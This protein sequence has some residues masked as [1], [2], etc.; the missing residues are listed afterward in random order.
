M[1]CVAALRGNT[2][3]E[4]RVYDSRNTPLVTALSAEPNP[5]IGIYTDA[6]DRTEIEGR[7]IYMNTRAL[8]LVLELGVASAETTTV[9]GQQI[10][11][12]VIPYTDEG[13]EATLDI[14]E[15]Q[16]IGCLFGNPR[17]EWTDLLKR[18]I[19]RITR[20]PSHRGGSAER[21]IRWAARQLTFV[22]D[23][24]FDFPPGSR[25]P[26][27]HPIWQFIE[28]ADGMSPSLGPAAD[29]V[30]SMLSE[31]MPEWRQQQAYA[32]LTTEEI[33]MMGL[34]PLYIEGDEQPPKLHKVTLEDDET[35]PPTPRAVVTDEDPEETL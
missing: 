24:V 32:G 20:I 16:A 15:S 19:T 30:R 26:A 5:Y 9:D 25:P 3:A 11:N 34:G 31:E 12:V 1:T 6:D 28:M 13:M 8:S 35:S 14:L 23:T 27:E 2:W 29:I 7:A 10:T 4:D 22:C 33:Q 18:F 21:S 17:G